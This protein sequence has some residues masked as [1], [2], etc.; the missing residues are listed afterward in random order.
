[1]SQ[2][3]YEERGRVAVITMSSPPVNGLGH[4]LRVA[5][6]KALEKAYV[7]RSV[8][9]IVVTGAGASFSAGADIR[10]IGSPKAFAAPNLAA[11]MSS[12]EEGPKPVVA[13]IHGHCL[14]GGLEFALGCHYRVAKP[15]ARIA[16]PEVKLGILP[17][18]GGTQRLPRVVGLEAAV[19][20]IVS[21]NTF[22]AAS[23]E[24]TGLF[25]QIVE[26]DLVASAV[27]FAERVIDEKRGFKRARDVM[28]VHPDAEGFLH[29]AR[30]TVRATSGPYPAPLR[31]LDAIEAAVYKPFDE[32][33]EYERE[34]LLDLVETPES[35]ALRHIFLSERVAAKIPGLDASVPLP[36]MA[37]AA[38]VGSGKMDSGVAMRLSHAGIPVTFVD[39]TALNEA[40][41]AS[42]D[43]VIEA[44]HGDIGMTRS[45]VER[46][47]TVMKPGAILAITTST[48]DLDRVAQFTKRPANV[49]GMH[50]VGHAK[51]GRLLE[52]VRGAKTSPES[53]ATVMKLAKTLRR[54]GVVTG[55]CKGFI[56]DRM[57]E[58]MNREARQLIAEGALEK[59]VNAAMERFG[60]ATGTIRLSDHTAKNLGPLGLRFD[61]TE[62]VDRLVFTLVNE[63]AKILEDGIA[64]RASDVDVVLVHGYGF[65]M[66]RGGPMLYADTIG[67][68]EV[69]RRMKR[70]AALPNG[71]PDA[72]RPADLLSRLATSGRTFNA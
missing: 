30:N 31:C 12:I 62:I 39:R 4:T 41:L 10:E 8:E 48:L 52:I 44:V 51:D 17:G 70:F 19:R 15:D 3:A 24:E 1:M 57:L 69:V 18:A 33:L 21:G 63:G 53:L 2:I 20:L 32:G 50:F 58:H 61:D 47:D 59:Q 71:D 49:V 29:F 11:I 13:A 34:V 43:I 14:G 6:A 9:A 42:A 22:D 16:L 45:E 7:S 37:R 68:D 36:P 35:K 66:H 65:P 54:L 38:V 56:G 25:D 67:L 60:F 72:W 40:S 64:Y 5:I 55:A 23:L 46:L 26:G 27:V 28:V